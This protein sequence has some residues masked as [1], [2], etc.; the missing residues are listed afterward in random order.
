[1]NEQLLPAIL[2]SALTI[3]VLLLF[4]LGLKK[5]LVLTGWETTHQNRI[6][7]ST[8]A[9]MLGWLL[10]V[11]ILSVKG[12]FS[13]FSALPPRP[14]LA[15]LI[16]LPFI[17]WISFSKRFCLLLKLVRPQWLVLMQSF[18]IAVEIFLFAAYIKK[19][20]PEQMTFGGWN[21]DIITGLLALPVGYYCFIKK[22][23][24]RFVVVLFNIMGLLLLI[25]VLVIAMLSM[26]T[27]FRYFTNEPSTAI[28]GSLPFIYLP[29]VLV[30]MA[31]T[32]HIFSL[33]QYFSQK[34]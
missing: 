18:R 21:F 2:L 9:A 10:L 14:A 15:I 20:L 31:Y 12:F 11:G 27:A 28:V 5:T 24:P 25:N 23:W 32:L 4:L 1:M 3:T 22:S 34:S 16:P 8:A 6:M 19:I 13:N 29:S 26:P 7:F 17:L 33:R 30:V